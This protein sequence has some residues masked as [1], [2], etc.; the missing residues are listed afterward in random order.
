MIKNKIS[1]VI[2][3]FV[4]S[5]LTGCGS[6]EPVP[7]KA[8]ATVRTS[9]VVTE[10]ITAEPIDNTTN[11]PTEQAS[12]IPNETYIGNANSKKFHRPDCNTLPVEKNRVYL[13][14]RE[15]AISTG[16]KACANCDP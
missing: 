8:P 7:T 1:F 9:P 2:L 3:L 11:S 10:K 13:H 16:F 4:I 12:E 14:S 6:A 15:E 5:T